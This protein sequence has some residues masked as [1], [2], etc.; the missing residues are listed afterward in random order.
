[1]SIRVTETY[2]RITM[3]DDGISRDAE[4]DSRTLPHVGVIHEKVMAVWV[5]AAAHRHAMS[6]FTSYVDGVSTVRFSVDHGDGTTESMTWVCR[7]SE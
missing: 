6:M 7:D 3:T 2:E 1:M 5:A 4:I